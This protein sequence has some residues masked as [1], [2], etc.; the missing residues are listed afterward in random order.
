MDFSSTKEYYKD[1]TI[2]FIINYY[3]ILANCY[4]NLKTSPYFQKYFRLS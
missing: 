1:S 4:L 3:F 2:K